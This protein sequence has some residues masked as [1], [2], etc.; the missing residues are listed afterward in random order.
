M[1]NKSV[2]RHGLHVPPYKPPQ[3]IFYSQLFFKQPPQ[4]NR[5]EVY[6][7]QTVIDLLKANVETGTRMAHGHPLTVPPDPAVLTHQPRLEVCRI[8]QRR[9]LLWQWPC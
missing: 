4:L 5:P 8:A 1:G 3:M 7:P 2:G 6:I 9:Q